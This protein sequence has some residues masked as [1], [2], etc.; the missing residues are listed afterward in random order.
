QEEGN[1]NLEPER[2]KNLELT[3]LF[4]LGGFELLATAYRMKYENYLYLGYSG[5]Q[6]AN[7]LPLKYWKQTDTTV[8][9]FE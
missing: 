4:H 2:A 6:T 9:G 8:K 5:M 3:G 1:Q 7:R